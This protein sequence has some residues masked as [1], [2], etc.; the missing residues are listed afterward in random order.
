MGF[1]REDVQKCLL[2]GEGIA[3]NQFNPTFFR[4][5]LERFVVDFKTVMQQHG[6][7]LS[8]GGGQQ[9]AALNSI[10]GTDPDLA[11]T[12]PAIKPFLVCGD[13]AGFGA[14]QEGVSPPNRMGIDEMADKVYEREHQNDSD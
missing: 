2:C 11:H 14:D 8:M 13:C 6:S 4:V 9:G 5:T 10:L 1:K 7:E 3:H 12:L